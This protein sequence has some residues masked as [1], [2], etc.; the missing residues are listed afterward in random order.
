MSAGFRAPG[1]RVFLACSLD[2]F[3]AGPGDDLS[4]LPSP[5]P[6]GEDYGYEAFIRE[7]KAILMGRRTYDVAASFDRWPYGDMPVYVA[8]SR[9]LDPVAE[10]VVPVIGSPAELLAAVRKRTDG[11]IYLDGGALIRAFVAEDLVDEL[12]ITIVPVVLGRGTP[13]FA[14]P[15]SPRPLVLISATPYPDGLVKLHYVPRR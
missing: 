1:V 8:T 11:A 14:G 3:I 7:T 10:T 9:P 13:L 12:T 15:A 4:W 2:G 6:G 5:D